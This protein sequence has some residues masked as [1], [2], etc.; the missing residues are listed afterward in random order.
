MKIVAGGINIVSSYVFWIHHEET[1]GDFDWSGNR[2]LRKFV[3]LCARL[4]LHVLLRP[5]PFVH[6]ECRN[7]GLSGFC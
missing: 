2:D 7:G 6:G 4:V 5:G 3:E 1:Q